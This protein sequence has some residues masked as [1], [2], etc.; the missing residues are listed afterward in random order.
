MEVQSAECKVQ[1]EDTTGASGALSVIHYTDERIPN[2]AP[3][4]NLA[5]QEY[6]TARNVLLRCCLRFGTVGPMLECPITDAAEPPFE[7]WAVAT[8]S[9]DCDYYLI[10]DQWN[11]E[12]YIY[13]EFCR[14]AAFTQ[15]W[16]EAIARTLV[17][18]PGWGVGLGASFQGGYVLIFEGRIMVTGP[19]F[20]GCCDLP[21]VVKAG[22]AAFNSG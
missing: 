9:C 21:S 12:K 14:A 18:L 20:A 10:D 2:P 7:D 15:Q 17:S 13:I 11:D 5:W 8:P 1:N 22:Q 4:G 3:G 16:V 6:Q 19:S